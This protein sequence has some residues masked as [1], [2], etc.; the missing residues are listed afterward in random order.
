MANLIITTYFLALSLCF[1]TTLSMF[2]M[3]RPKKDLCQP[4]EIPV[5]RK[6]G[7]NK[8][9][10]PTDLYPSMPFQEVKKYIE[11]LDSIKCSKDLLFFLCTIYSPVCFAEY[12][13]RVLPC[14]SVCE[15]VKE[16]CMPY[17][18]IAGFT[19][20]SE[21]DC[22]RLPDYNTGVCIQPSAIVSRKC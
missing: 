8:T 6:L 13:P 15:S 4:L 14:R 7:Y 19:W 22:R 1:C 20:P 12:V 10:I 18:R 5:C 17:V 9:R 3:H 11:L 2:A 21:L 16:G